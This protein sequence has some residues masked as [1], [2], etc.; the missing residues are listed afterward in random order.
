[1]PNQRSFVF[2]SITALILC[3]VIFAPVPAPL[4]AQTN[5]LS[6]PGFEIE[7]N[8]TPV[9]SGGGGVFGAPPNWG[10]WFDS[11]SASIPNGYPHI[12]VFVDE[13][14]TDEE[15]GVANGSNLFIHGGNRSA[16][17]GR[18]GGAFTGAIYQQAAVNVG[19]NVVGS[20]WVIMNLPGGA[21]FQARV[22]VDPNGGTN[23]GDTDIVW[24]DWA[25]N[26]IQTYRQLTASATATGPAVT[27][28]LYFRAV[29][30]VDPNGI[31]WDD[32]SLVVG[33]A[34]GVA[35]GT[36]PGTG[37]P[38]AAAATVPPTAPPVA[39]FVVPQGAQADGSI[40]HTVVTGDT[41][42][43][44]AVAYGVQPAQILELNN[45]SDGRLLRVG[46]Q[47]IIKPPT[48]PGSDEDDA[49]AEEET[50]E[51]ETAEEAAATPTESADDAETEE[52][53]ASGSTTVAQAA[54]QVPTSD[55]DETPEPTP[56]DEPTP[57]PTETT[58]PTIAPT[59]P[60]AEADTDN[61]IDPTNPNATVC[62]TLFEDANQNRIR[63]ADEALIEGGTLSLSTG[64]TQVDS[65]TTDGATDPYCAENLAPG[66]YVS[67]VELPAGY[68]STTPARRLLDLQP[69]TTVNIAFGGAQGVEVA[70]PPPANLGELNEVVVDAAPVED[71][72]T[73]IVQYLGLILF[74]LAG[75]TL[76]GGIGATLLLRRR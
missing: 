11:S 47:L 51:E 6:N 39:A 22:G 18:G 52:T 8:W 59:A 34:G 71:N 13:N 16:N 14:A 45:L 24:S 54:T 63:E 30:P 58:P 36:T 60:V 49:A 65:F 72:D 73:G 55:D 19:D 12:R 3:A 37:V 17:F 26:Q 48:G 76:L 38:A 21:N 33:G 62:L 28:F 32:A 20:A 70:A 75:L 46:Q 74:G 27:L 9:A 61:D 69:G 40:V 25:Q 53:P 7:G 44:I 4:Y 2:L 1:M 29:A 66:D 68:G 57:T 23:P 56:T 42:N 15:K 67:M 50:S 31:Y 43:A 41:L 64:D 10:G 5:L 35:P